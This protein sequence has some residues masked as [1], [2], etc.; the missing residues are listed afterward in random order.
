MNQQINTLL[1]NA[2]GLPQPPIWVRALSFLLDY[3]LLSVISALIIT[4]FLLPMNPELSWDGLIAWSEQYLSQIQSKG[5][6]NLPVPNQTI[7]ETLLFITE[8]VTFLF[9]IYFFICDYFLKGS[10]IGK[11]IFNIRTLSLLKPEKIPLSSALMRSA[12]KTLILFY[13][14]PIILSVAILTKFFHKSKQWGHD[15]I[16]QTKVIDEFKVAELLKNQ[17]TS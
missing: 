17:I 11:R 13:F 12:A 3:C 15:L 2:D 4:Q 5:T 8:S 1:I 14:F 16:S 9:L 6:E 10:S 7:Q